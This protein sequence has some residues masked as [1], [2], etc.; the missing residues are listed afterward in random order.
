MVTFRGSKASSKSFANQQRLRR[1]LPIRVL[2]KNDVLWWLI[3]LVVI[4]Y[5][6]L[7]ATYYHYPDSNNSDHSNNNVPPNRHGNGNTHNNNN[8]NAASGQNSQNETDKGTVAACL[9]VMDDNHFLVEWI[10]YHYHA[11][12]LRKLVVAIDP[13]S[14]TSPLEILGRWKHKIQITVWTSDG[15]YIDIENGEFE[16]ARNAVQKTFRET[17]PS[18]I[19]HRARQRLFYTHCLRFLKNDNDNDSERRSSQSQSQSALWTMLVDVDEF[20]RFNY[21]TANEWAAKNNKNNGNGK[22]NEKT[23]SSFRGDF[24]HTAIVPIDQPRSVAAVLQTLT[25]PASDA[26][27]SISRSRSTNSTSDDNSNQQPP[28]EYLKTSPCIPL[29]RVRF[30]SKEDDETKERT[31]DDSFLTQT[32]RSHAR[33]EDFNSNKISKTIIDLSRIP[34][35][36][37]VDVDSIHMPI[38]KY[39]SQRN[40]FFFPKDS[41]LVIN[42]YLGSYEQFTYR[43]ND[44]RNEISQTSR[45]EASNANTTATKVNVRDAQH[46]Q[47]QQRFRYTPE[48][49]DEIKPWLQGFIENQKGAAKELLK[50]S[51]Q[52]APKSWRTIFRG[53]TN[54]STSK[55]T[56]QTNSDDRCALLFFGLTRSYEEIVLPSLIENVLKPNAR[57]GCDV[58]VHFYKQETENPGR[59]NEG[60][61]LRPGDIFLLE[62]A[63]R[64]VS[65]EYYD[66]F[67]LEHEYKVLPEDARPSYEPPIVAFAHDTPEEFFERRSE[68][69]RKYQEEKTSVGRTGPNDTV[70]AYFPWAVKSYKKESLDNIVRQWHSIQSAFL[71]MDYTSR[72]QK[73]S[74]TRV[75][76]FRS[77]CLYVTP[78]DI[79][80]LGN[81]KGPNGMPMYDVNNKHFVIPSFALHPVNDRLVYG[82]YDAI[83]IW[84][85]KR[86]DL[87]EESARFQTNPGYTMHSERFL[88]ATIFPAMEELGFG[89]VPNGNICFLRTRVGGSAFVNDCSTDGLLPTPQAIEAWNKKPSADTNKLRLS[90]VESIVRKPCIL[91]NMSNNPR[92]TFASCRNK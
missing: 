42:H 34:L 33:G 67:L 38:R 36:D 75:G 46:F 52:L 26:S 21:R 17:T 69:L 72:L 22:K 71:L 15:D 47:D 60:G 70:P 64:S 86:F 82:P 10:A 5:M 9:L 54:G 57:H 61:D 84:A 13:K 20:V 91:N 78:I 49:D 51:G 58:Y 63:V 73:M 40:R 74:Y 23:H 50:D 66:T 39:C 79:A 32:Y 90:L 37:I 62:D 55:I 7:M 12:G 8:N 85:T 76:M 19:D 18:L 16:A 68:Q 77:D 30:V 4:F 48:T 59:R 45:G 27:S 24:N 88:N 28:W 83:K 92:W 87:V 14:T 80:S 25:V 1:G 44:A 3:C 11:V 31:G 89:R 81:S 2:R 41:L 43:E 6:G 35:E 65:R 56:A 29:P 53:N